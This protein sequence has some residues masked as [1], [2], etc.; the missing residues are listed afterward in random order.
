M[1]QRRYFCWRL[2]VCVGPR[3]SPTPT[4][5]K[6]RTREVRQRSPNLGGGGGNQCIGT[7]AVTKGDS[8]K[9][10]LFSS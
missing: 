2:R 7:G 6:S 4:V 3:L 5:P 8:R 10:S 1:T 9:P